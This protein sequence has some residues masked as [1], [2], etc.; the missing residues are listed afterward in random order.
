M[1]CKG[2][3]RLT[4]YTT[5]GNLENEC[6]SPQTTFWLHTCIYIHMY[7]H[8]FNNC[9]VYMHVCIHVLECLS[10]P[11]TLPLSFGRVR[12]V[13]PSFPYLLVRCT[14]IATCHNRTMLTDRGNSARA[15]ALIQ[16]SLRYSPLFRHLMLCL[17]TAESCQNAEPEQC[18]WR[19]VVWW[20]RRGGEEKKEKTST[21]RAVRLQRHG[22]RWGHAHIA[23]LQSCVHICRHTCMCVKVIVCESLEKWSLNYVSVWVPA[24]QALT[25]IYN[26]H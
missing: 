16:C 13:A 12:L 23:L 11:F 1:S 18:K 22:G 21:E 25:C 8:V 14:Y 24:W 19:Q 17:C 15:C 5:L 2:S 9:Y 10:S 26:L 20:R 7:I 3:C 4:V 6:F